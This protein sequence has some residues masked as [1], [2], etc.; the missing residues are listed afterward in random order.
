MRLRQQLSV[1]N[2]TAR[3]GRGTMADTVLAVSKRPRRKADGGAMSVGANFP[4]MVLLTGC[5][6]V[7]VKLPCSVH[8]N[9]T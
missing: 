5:S 4:T 7:A 2:G 6:D 9:Q 3:L 8:R 1:F